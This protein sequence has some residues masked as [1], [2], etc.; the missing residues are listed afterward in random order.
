METMAFLMNRGL[1]WLLPPWD[2]HQSESTAT[3]E[4]PHQ[5][6]NTCRTALPRRQRHVMTVHGEGRGHGRMDGGPLS[7]G[8]GGGSL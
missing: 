5:H 1:S 8:G 2:G 6:I 7:D 4:E 3:D